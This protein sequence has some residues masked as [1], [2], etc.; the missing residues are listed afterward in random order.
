MRTHLIA[1][2]AHKVHGAALFEQDDY[3]WVWWWGK[4]DENITTVLVH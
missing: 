4:E 1:L 2:R 3:I